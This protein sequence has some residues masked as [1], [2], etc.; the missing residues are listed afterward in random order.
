MMGIAPSSAARSGQRAIEAILRGE[1]E[2]VDVPV[3]FTHLAI[4]PRWRPLPAEAAR[5][6]SQALGP[7]LAE[8]PTLILYR[9]P[10][11]TN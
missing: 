1:T 6:L 9:I 5:R 8:G 7:P 2:Q 11:K 3:D 10:A 4:D